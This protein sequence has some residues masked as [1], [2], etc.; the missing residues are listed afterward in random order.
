VPG[1]CVYLPGQTAR[2]PLRLPARPLDRVEFNK[3]L[4]EGDRRQGM[5]LYRPTCPSCHACQAIRIDVADFH[6][7]RTQRRVLR[8]GDDLFETEIGKPTLTLEKV[9]LYN[10]HKIERGLVVGDDLVDA[11][12]YEQFL[13]ETCT[14]SIEIRYRIG[15]DLV[16][17]AISDRAADALS[18]VYFYFDPD[19]AALS[20]GVYSILKQIELCREW[21]LRHLYLGLYVAGCRSLAYKVDYHPHERL[22]GG[23][24]RRYERGAG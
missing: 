5:L 17:V 4:V 8:R 12:G 20:P 21:G 1:P 22:V 9:R 19:H 24:W 2:L 3:R 7:G 18:A 11:G 16:G 10:R 15:D 6:P 13:V 14:E 23:E